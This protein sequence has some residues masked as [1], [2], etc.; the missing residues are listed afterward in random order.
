MPGH[1]R[2]ALNVDR[3][4]SAA[5]GELMNQYFG[6]V[7]L[8]DFEGAAACFTPGAS[9]EYGGLKLPDGRAA[10]VEFLRGA[11]GTAVSSRHIGTSVLAERTSAT[12]GR[13]E[14]AAVVLA[15]RVADTEPELHIRGIR[16]SDELVRF[17]GEWLISKRVHRGEWA[18]VSDVS[19]LGHPEFTREADGS[20]R[21]R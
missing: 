7:D 5:A 19:V 2:H 9:S 11:L 3:Q 16:Y 6:C 14:T 20:L 8:G 4:L 18:A 17:D 15:V 21:R 12:T 13:S 10:I 1:V